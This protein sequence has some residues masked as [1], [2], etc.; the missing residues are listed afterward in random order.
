[1]EIAL[2]LSLSSSLFTVNVPC[3]L[4][5]STTLG[6]PRRFSALATDFTQNM[7]L[8]LQTLRFLYRSCQPLQPAQRLNLSQFSQTLLLQ[9]R[10]QS[11]S[12]AATLRS[13]LLTDDY[14]LH[15]DCIGSR[16]CSAVKHLTHD[17]HVTKFYFRSVFRQFAQL[18]TNSRNESRII[19]IT[20]T[21][22]KM[23]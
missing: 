6:T 10:L 18:M 7:A 13:L 17:C 22:I 16:A 3:R 11:S 20:T 23:F 2:S 1:V 19:I 14:F 9:T 4:V 12:R 15:E 8:T 21:T 5:G